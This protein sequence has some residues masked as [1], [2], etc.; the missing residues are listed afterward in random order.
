MKI[1]GNYKNSKV[2]FDLRWEHNRG[3]LGT[4]SENFYIYGHKYLR[5]T[6]LA[7]HFLFVKFETT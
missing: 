3:L 1:K 4:K 2:I 5:N 7:K 6:D